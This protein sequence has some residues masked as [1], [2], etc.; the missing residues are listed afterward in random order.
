[1]ENK[2]LL[3]RIE[4]ANFIVYYKIFSSFDISPLFSLTLAILDI[5]QLFSFSFSTKVKKLN[6]KLV[7]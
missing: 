6:L 7:F 1:M 4:H 5:G 3:N 2:N